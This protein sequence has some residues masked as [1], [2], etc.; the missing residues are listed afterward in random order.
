MIKKACVMLFSLLMCILTAPAVL[1]VNEDLSEASGFDRILPEQIGAIHEAE[2]DISTKASSKFEVKVK[3]N[4]IIR[5]SF[6]LP[7]AENE[8]ITITCVYS[9]STADIDLGLITPD[10]VYRLFSGEEGSFNRSIRVDKS[11]EYYL[12][13]RNNTDMTVE[14][15]GYLYY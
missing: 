5:G 12:A 1:A 7:L 13:L 9:P 4:S 14:V 2:V 8:V 11:G 6:A 15:I 10:D 3:P